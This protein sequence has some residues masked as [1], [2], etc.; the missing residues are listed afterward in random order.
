[1]VGVTQKA[2]LFHILIKKQIPVSDYV[3]VLMS[4]NLNFVD[5]LPLI[6]RYADRF[7]ETEYKEIMDTGL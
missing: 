6:R 4:R 2:G 1:L 3:P 5:I 7:T